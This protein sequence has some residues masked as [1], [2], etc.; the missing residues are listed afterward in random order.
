MHGE[1]YVISDNTVSGFSEAI[2]INLRSGSG[3]ISGNTVSDNQTG[4]KLGFGPQTAEGNVL[5]DNGIGI[6]SPGNEDVL[7]NNTIAGGEVGL[8]VRGTADVVGN[9]IEDASGR[10]IV[11]GGASEATLR[12]NRSCGNEDNLWVS[13]DADPDVDSTNEI[14]GDDA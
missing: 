14:C 7:K 9:T 12:D 11:I 10:G 1:G 3:T 2:G 8:S 5:I 6:T 4:I 13:D